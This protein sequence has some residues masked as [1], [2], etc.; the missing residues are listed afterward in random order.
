MQELV[1][2]YREWRKSEGLPFNPNFV[3]K[4][5][6]GLADLEWKYWKAEEK[7]L[8]FEKGRDVKKAMEVSKAL[9]PARPRKAPAYITRKQ[10][11]S[12]LETIGMAMRQFMDPFIKRIEQLEAHQLK[13]CDVWKEGTEYTRGNFVSWGG[14]VWHCNGAL[15]NDSDDKIIYIPTKA[16][17]GQSQDWTLAVK[18]G[19]DGKDAKP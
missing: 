17:P 11:D 2:E 5:Y 6:D 1:K 3:P 12:T 18:R 15:S 4:S 10:L 16:K 7:A 14:S 13:Y 9:P 19:R 8:D